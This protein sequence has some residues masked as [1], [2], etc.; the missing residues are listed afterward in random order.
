VG[1]NPTRLT[2]N[3]WDPVEGPMS[4]LVDALD[5]LMAEHR[6]I[7]S[8]LPDF[9]LPG[10]EP[11]AIRARIAA[12]ELDP[13]D[14]VVELFSW[15]NGVDNDRYLSG[16]AGIGYGRLFD[17]VFFGTV[18]EAVTYYGECLQIDRITAETYD[19]PGEPIWRVTW[20]PPFSA[21]LPTFGIEC[22]VTSA[23]RGM[24]FQPWW[25]PPIE[26]PIRPRFRSLT[27]LVESIVRRFEA[28]GYWW[29]RD[30]GFLEVRDEVIGPLEEREKLE[31]TG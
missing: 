8:P 7:G 24:V 23:S 10:L 16:G 30:V 22:D 19:D 20:F 27:H 17:D 29:D 26:E 2:N 14:E 18:D 13:P 3:A 21:G 9:L 1:S 12:L 31:A 11:A 6:R 15:H 5:R 25:H 28:D 4:A